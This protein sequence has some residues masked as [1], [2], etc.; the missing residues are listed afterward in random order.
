MM[1]IKRLKNNLLHLNNLRK[2]IGYEIFQE[3]IESN[4]KFEILDKPIS[5]R[6]L[7]LSPHPDDDVIGCGGSIKLHTDNNEPVKIV[8]L[9]DGSGGMPKRSGI[10]TVK[11]SKELAKIRE[12]EAINGAAILGVNDTVFWRYRDSHLVINNSTVKFMGSLLS[13]YKPDIIYTP[14]FLDP[15]PDHFETCKILVEALKKDNNFK[16][17]IYSYEVWSP[18]YANRIVKL[19]GA[20]EAKIKAIGAHESQL[21]SRAYLEAI[22]GL[23]KYR[24]GMY[25]AGEYAEAF[26]A[27]NKKLYLQLFNLLNLKNK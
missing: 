10:S 26:F 22:M 19:E 25:N 23:A 6:V 24:A 14:S 20:V 16:G 12:K 8:Y 13:E 27:C 9:T 4:F 3:A 15:H 18:I 11:D 17:S 1:N 5:G 21:Q 2:F 7:V